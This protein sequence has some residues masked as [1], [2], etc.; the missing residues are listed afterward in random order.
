L[1]LEES[2]ESLDLRFEVNDVE[3][4]SE[5]R[6]DKGVEEDRMRFVVEKMDSAGMA[7]V[8]AGWKR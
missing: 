1:G 2:E 8:F 4:G 5:V 6:E 3:P 7:S